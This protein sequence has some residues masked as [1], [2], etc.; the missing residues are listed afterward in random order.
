MPPTRFDFLIL[1]QGLAGSALAWQLIHAGARLCVIDDGHRSSSSAVAAGLINPLAGLRFTRRPE[2][3][4]WLAAADRWY[5]ALAQRFGRPFFHPLPL[6]RL[7]RSPQQRRF[8]ERCLADPAAVDLIGDAFGADACPEPVTAPHGG[9]LQHRTGYVEL[10]HL[11][12]TLRD[13]LRERQALLEREL[14]LRGIEVDPSGVSALGLRAQ[15]LVF[16]DGARLRDNRWFTDLPLRPE[17]GEILDLAPADWRPRHILNGA[18]WLLPQRDGVLR[19]GATHDHR[20]IDARTTAAAR[21]EL[22]AGLRAWRPDAR[23]P[24]VLRQQAGIRPGTADRYPLLGRRGAQP[25][26]WVFNGFGARGALSIPWYAERLA[27]HLLHD[28]PLPAEADIRRF[29]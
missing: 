22:L 7:F 2:T 8:Y 6:L 15:A 10:P 20:R 28:A 25:R 14:P 29:A 11:L 3:S 18:H 12:A 16:C 21:D 24:R 19:L 27:A 23:P 5:A 26:L 13:W 17:K 1:G 9:F 4:D